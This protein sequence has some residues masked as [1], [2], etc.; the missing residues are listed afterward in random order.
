M[1]RNESTVNSKFGRISINKNIFFRQGYKN[2][3]SSLKNNAEI[4]TEESLPTATYFGFWSCF[5]PGLHFQLNNNLS[6]II[7]KNFFA[8]FYYIL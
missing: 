8:I 6:L 1:I 5:E 7:I 3:K 2:L 4:F